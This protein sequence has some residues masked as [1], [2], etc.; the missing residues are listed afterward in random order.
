MFGKR[1]SAMPINVN[2]RIE[3]L[4]VPTEKDLKRIKTASQN[5]GEVYELKQSLEAMKKF[6][7][8]SLKTASDPT[9]PLENRSI[10]GVRTS[11]MR[12]VR[13]EMED[14][15]KKLNKH[16]IVV[17]QRSLS[18]GGKVHYY[19]EVNVMGFDA[20]SERMAIYEATASGKISETL[21]NYFLANVAY[22]EACYTKEESDAL[23]R[24]Y[25]QAAKDK[26]HDMM[27][28]CKEELSDR[29][30]CTITVTHARD[31]VQNAYKALSDNDKDILKKLEKDEDEDD[32]DDNK[33]IE[34]LPLS[35]HQPPS[36]IKDYKDTDKN[37]LLGVLKESVQND[38]IS[39]SRS[40]KIEELIENHM[41]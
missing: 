14:I 22:M 35:Y 36:F 23:V 6:L 21:S 8:M 1:K 4:P 11:D 25:V 39:F 16:G 38:I 28:A 9:R 2:G 41:N 19:E 15:V 3:Y 10:R 29:P 5:A 18:G 27:T 7:D 37:R 26:D 24:A 13:R 33:E 34:C 31:D 30:K 12:S 32:T 17:D 20:K 40:K